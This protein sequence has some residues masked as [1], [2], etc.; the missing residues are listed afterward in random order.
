MSI[1]PEI[2]LRLQKSSLIW[3]DHVGNG[4]RP[5]YDLNLLDR[6][7]DVGI[8]IASLN[9]GYDVLHW[10]DAIKN[11][12][13]FRRW[14][15][16][17]GHR[18]LLVETADD[19]L[20]ARKERKLGIIFDIEGVNALDGAIDM[21]SLYYRLGVRQMLFVYNR[22]NLAGGGCHDEDIGLTSFG[23]EV[24]AEMNRVGMMVDCSHCSRRTSLETIDL[25][26]TPVI[27]SH[28]NSAT[29]RPHGRNISDEQMKACAR[30]GGIVGING[31]GLFLGDRTG[32]AKIFVDHLCYAAELIGPEHV[33][34]GLDYT[35][36]KVNFAAVTARHPEYWPESEGY[37]EDNT[38]KHIAPEQLTEVIAELLKRGFSESD[39]RCILGEN[40]LK[41]VKLVWK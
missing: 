18:F 29:L 11:V 13:A 7:R 25:S 34:I 8:T 38:Y 33:A 21:I 30:R 36:E 5:D 23:R 3:D 31:I 28:S 37:R 6:W 20:K 40:F 9:I 39:V 41:L 32:N 1:D 16:M 12:A 27:F 26:A 22:N 15:A 2:A 24:L 19:V 10:T 14:L 17:N 35:P 4:P